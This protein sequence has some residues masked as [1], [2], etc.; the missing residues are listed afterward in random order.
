VDE[1]E[2]QSLEPSGMMTRGEMAYKMRLRGVPTV[3]IANELRIDPGSVSRLI[4]EQLGKHVADL[5]PEER[6]NILQLEFNRLDALLSAVWD[7][8]MYGDPKSQQ[9]ALNN[10]ALQAKLGR[11]DIPDAAANAQQVLII[12]GKEAEY[13]AK[14]RELAGG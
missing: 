10:I 6:E 7:S 4:N 3:E 13:V 12:G 1:N 2:E 5:E 8:A 11:M 9:L 14:L